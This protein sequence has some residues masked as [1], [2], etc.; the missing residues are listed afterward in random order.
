MKYDS[1]VRADL[2][3]MFSGSEQLKLLKASET[4]Y[5][6]HSSGLAC[7]TWSATVCLQTYTIIQNLMHVIFF[8]EEIATYKMLSE[9]NHT[10]FL[11]EKYAIQRKKCYTVPL[12]GG[13]YVK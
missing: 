12:W 3:D 6:Q 7:S 11:L 4:G 9:P 13:G 10:L 8:K 1:P 5:I 2:V